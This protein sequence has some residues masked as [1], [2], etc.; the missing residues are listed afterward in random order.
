MAAAPACP[1]CPSFWRPRSDG[2]VGA[3][4]PDSVHTAHG[5]PA[6][7]GAL[8]PVSSSWRCCWAASRCWTCRTA[9]TSACWPTMWK[10]PWTWPWTPS[11]RRCRNGHSPAR[12]P[13]ADRATAVQGFYDSGGISTLRL[14]SNHY[15]D[16]ATAEHRLRL[17]SGL[18]EL[19]EELYEAYPPP[20]ATRS[21]RVHWRGALA[22]TWTP[23]P[24]R[25]PPTAWRCT[26]TPPAMPAS[27]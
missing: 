22:G 7:A 27:R 12:P 24:P 11:R 8:H 5:L 19:L 3:H 13:A 2:A 16:V 1:R 26:A 4:R 23:W 15:A 9:C 17:S 10:R 25:W 21:G 18:D 14:V 6:G 20:A